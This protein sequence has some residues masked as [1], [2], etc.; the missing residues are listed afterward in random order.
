[1]R[2]CE[3]VVFIGGAGHSGSTLLGLMLG[4]SPSV[5]YAGEARK[6]LFLGDETKP[7]KKRVCKLCGPSC[8]V[9]GE[10]DIP[11]D[12]DLYEA[13]ARTTGRSIVVDSTKNLG[14][15]DR[16]LAALEGTGAA[17]LLIFLARDGR[18]V[19]TSRLRKYPKTPAR[20]H[21]TD[22]VAQIRATEELT[23]R[24]PGP[25]LR[26]R[27]EELASRTEPVL[28]E[29]AEFV[30]VPFSAPML[31]PW[32]T[33]QH[34]LGGNNG[35]QFLFARERAPGDGVVELTEKTRE[36]YGA[37]PRGVV[38]DLRWKREMS[39]QAR[40]E[41]DAV[42]GEANAPYAWNDAGETA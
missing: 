33:E 39:A 24:F 41:F 6:S 17:R 42:A 3:K 5:F 34:P 25:V 27:Y 9:W 18:A 12:V 31:A 14:W 19:V 28:R 13:L 40:A 35:T 22:W 38:L 10:L 37:H 29:V 8:R 23:A 1:M 7:L 30:G 15:I 32:T 4:A 20:E 11:A 2:H 21:A 16:Q 36:H 26:L